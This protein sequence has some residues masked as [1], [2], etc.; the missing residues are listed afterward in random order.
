MTTLVDN[1]YL[2][3]N[4]N[5]TVDTVTCGPQMAGMISGATSSLKG[6]TDEITQISSLTPWDLQAEHLN[7]TY[8][9]SPN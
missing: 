4:R 6:G 3:R 7:F 5:G 8:K 1:L 2:V 9:Q